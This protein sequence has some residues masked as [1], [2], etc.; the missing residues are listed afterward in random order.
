MLFSMRV[1]G[2]IHR[3]EEG[4]GARY[5]R[6]LVAVFGFLAVGFLYD[7][8]CLRHFSNAEAMDAAQL[9]RNISQ[10]QKFRTDFVRPFSM[11]LVA[12]QRADRSTLLKE[13][14]PDISN[15]PVY[16]IVLAPVL[17]GSA[18]LAQMTA[19]KS[20]T[21]YGHSFYIILFNQ[22]LLGIGALLVFRLALSWFDR[23][24]A[25][26][27]T[28]LFVLTELY[29]RFSISGLSTILLIDI[30][31]V[32][33]W[34]LCRFERHSREG[35]S[36]TKLIVLTGAIGITTALAMLTL[37]S[38][39]WLIVPVVVFIL[40]CSAR[41]RGLFAVVTVVAFTL[42]SLPW[43]ART[44]N[45]SGWPFGTATFAPLCDTQPFPGDKLER[46]LMPTFSGLPG[47]R[48]TLIWGMI[49]KGVTNLREIVV[50]E[51]P[52]MGGNWLWAFFIVGILVRFKNP[53]LSRVR[54]FIAAT[55][56]LMLPIQALV[57]T[58]LSTEVPIVNSENLLVIF[59]P[60]V[61]ILGT[62]VF[63]VL[64][65][66]WLPPSPAWH[67]SGIGAFGILISLPMLLALAPPQP[68]PFA[69][70]Y[71]PPRI[72]Q[73][74]GYVNEQELLMSDIP[75]ATAWYGDRQS[76]WLTLNWQ[77]DFLEVTDSQKAVNG[78]YVST[79]TTDSKLFSNWFGYD[80]EGWGDF[81]AQAFLRKDVPTRFPLKRSPEGI[82]A[83][84]ELLLMDRD[85]WSNSSGP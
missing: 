49:H 22:L 34:L 54:W 24:V 67:H 65:D 32:L 62:G 51:L 72:Q 28:I 20:L 79:R 15:A 7:S 46:S 75:W 61:L 26:L 19:G 36:T 55:V 14:H 84:G 70:P 74:A 8:L 80:R 42:V 45:I 13:G 71:Y 77:K 66:T 85:R 9:G 40:A 47:Y 52:R 44:T 60:L 23:T 35:A 81:L 30:V 27:S 10:G 78:L 53:T 31:L 39:G 83:H 43:I 17:R 59:S 38:L 16:P 73:I 25:W 29:W 68:R 21:Q 69:P 1:Q 6:W 58:H 48:S 12:N 64:L 57:K 76:V 5:L 11:Y 41:Q 18:K 33:V 82:F 2:W 3:L 63:I 4:A 50:S 56:A 37:Y